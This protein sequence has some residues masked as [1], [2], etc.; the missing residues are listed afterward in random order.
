MLLWFLV[1]YYCNETDLVLLPSFF[2]DLANCFINKQNY[3]WVMPSPVLP[4]EPAAITKSKILTPRLQR[5]ITYIGELGLLLI[6]LT[7]TPSTSLFRNAMGKDS[8][9]PINYVDLD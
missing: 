3:V 9:D 1:W 8:D 6:F 4:N 7:Q 5:P 2:I